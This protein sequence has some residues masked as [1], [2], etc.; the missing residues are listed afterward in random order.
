[1]FFLIFKIYIR[2]I[3]LSRGFIFVVQIHFY[4]KN[5]VLEVLIVF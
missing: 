3:K 5:V 1:M 4:A 2:T